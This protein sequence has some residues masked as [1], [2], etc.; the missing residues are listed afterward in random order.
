[1]GQ[2]LGRLDTSQEL[3]DFDFDLDMD[4]GSRWAGFFIHNSLSGQRRMSTG[5][6]SRQKGNGQSDNPKI[7]PKMN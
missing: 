5:G 3:H 2:Q 4:V 6:S 1:M 7:F